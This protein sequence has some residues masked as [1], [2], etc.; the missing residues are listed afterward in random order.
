[1]KHRCQPKCWIWRRFVSIDECLAGRISSYP[2]LEEGRVKKGRTGVN[3]D[4][5]GVEVDSV[6]EELLLVSWRGCDRVD[7][8]IHQP[9]ETAEQLDNHLERIGRKNEHRLA[10]ADVSVHIETSWWHHMGVESV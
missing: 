10:R 7:E 6:S 8:Q 2:D 5:E 1:M 9:A 3:G 4:H